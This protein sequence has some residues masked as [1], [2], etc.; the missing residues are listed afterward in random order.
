MGSQGARCEE[1][2]RP[3]PPRPPSAKEQR[4]CPGSK[5]RSAWHAKRKKAALEEAVK[6][7]D[8]ALA[9]VTRESVHAPLLVAS[10]RAARQH[11][12]LAR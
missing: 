3:L 9:Y 4:F 7:L 2:D 1:C 6:D 5:C 12:E 11:L 10:I 8:A